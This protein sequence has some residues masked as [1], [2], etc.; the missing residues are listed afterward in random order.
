MKHTTDERI[1][2]AK[3][4]SKE[5]LIEKMKTTD[6]T[7]YDQMLIESEERKS[8]FCV[9]YKALAYSREPKTL[10]FP[11]F[12]D[13]I[14]D[15]ERTIEQSGEPKI[16]EDDKL[17]QKII[18]KGK[19]PI[20]TPKYTGK[21]L[22]FSELKLVLDAEKIKSKQPL[23]YLPSETERCTC[24]TC[25][26]DMYTT[27][28]E[29]E[30]R[31][32]HIYDCNEC[33]ATGE[34]E[35][36]TCKGRGE[37]KCQGNG[38]S[39]G[40]ENGRIKCS[41]CTGNGYDREQ[42]RCN[43]RCT[44]G[45]ID[46]KKCGGK[47]MVECSS[48]NDHGWGN[49]LLV[50]AV[51]GKKDFCNGRGKVTCK[52]CAGKRQIICEVCYGDHIDSRYGK[53]DCA[54]CETAGEL[55][56]I[57]YIETVIKSDNLDLT[58]TNGKKIEAPNF[59]VENIK[60][61]VNP[62][63]QLIL[64]YKNLNGENKENYDEYSTFCSKSALTEIGSSK[65][66]YPKL[67]S[68][69]MYYEGVPCATFNYNHILSAT[70]HDVSVLSVD[71]EQDVLFHSNPT[72][73]AEEKESFKEK[74]N[75]LCRRAFST[76][77]YKDKIDRKHEMFL[78]VHMA[79]ADGIIEEQEKK[80]LAQTITGLDGFT[81]KEKVELF[82]LMSASTLPAILPTNAYFSSKE[83]AAETRKKIIEL[84]AKADGE[85]EPQE[86]AKLDEINNS[87]E[88]GY[89][90]KPS[91]LGR[92]LKTWQVSVSMFLLLCIVAVGVYFG[93]VIYPQIK[94][95]KE[96]KQKAEMERLHVATNISNNKPHTK[97]SEQKTENIQEEKVNTEEE[98][99]ANWSDNQILLN[100][101]SS[102][103]IGLWKGD[104][105]GKELTISINDITLDM[106]VTGFDEV[107]GNKRDLKG[108]VKESE[109]GKYS[110]TL[111]EPGDDKWDGV[112]FITYI[113][114]ETNLKGSWKANNGK[115]SK[116]FELT[117]Q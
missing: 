65:E 82:G 55:A 102:S 66:R 50:K 91:V 77:A 44:N 16:L 12:K 29:N 104:F 54:T 43:K 48:R 81:N 13:L 94:A 100:N 112:F 79:K 20:D 98:Q 96:T 83:R 23:Y 25:Q 41:S 97:I 114:G 111:K 86:K 62:N 64:T 51:S 21:K 46:C 78:M 117:K 87:I 93:L 39:E 18:A 17:I 80:Y 30:C 73:I 63:G 32:E 33:H 116:D 110:I 58:F 9:K 74:V 92:F 38:P 99:P 52:K 37:F 36:S 71:K 101:L 42:K 49:N 61:Y 84:V 2:N 68:E 28:R 11:L 53:V 107:K 24:N 4:V 6:P 75:E 115:S 69:E 105:G 88:L 22:I 76:K 47:G 106:A 89:K 35:C 34:K 113:D 103:L 70:Y 45:W 14:N 108:E 57:S 15:F 72:A 5:R 40:C 8:Y 27:C 56:S 95:E 1:K 67:I 60:K 3:E 7:R 85:Y 19:S 59:G 31:G 26:G 10:K 109:N 90:A